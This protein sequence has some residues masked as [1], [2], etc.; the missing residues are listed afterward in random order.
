MIIYE[1]VKNEFMMDVE[2]DLLVTKVINNF[3]ER[4]GSTSE[5]EVNSWRNSLYRMYIV[6]NHDSIPPNV[7]IAIEYRIPTSSRRIDFIISGYGQDKGVAVIV[8]LKQWQ[9]VE[10]V[11]DK[12][13]I[14]RTVLGRG[15]RE[16]THPAYQVYSYAALLYDFNANVSHNSIRL[17]PCAYLHN[18]T[19]ELENDPLYD[20]SYQEYI[21]KAPVFDSTGIP[22]LRSFISRHVVKGD[23]KEILYLIE[24]GKIR[25]SKSLQDSLV[26]MLDGNAEFT[27]IDE[28]KVVYE[29]VKYSATQ[30]IASNRKK[31]IIVKG[32]PGTGKSVL[33][34][35]LLVHL[36]NQNLVCQYISKNSAPRQVYTAQLKGHKTRSS[37][38][39]LFKGSGVYYDLPCNDL[40]VALVD[41]AHRLNEKSGMFQ[42]KG[43]HQ[44][45]E[46][47]HAS[48]VSVFFID[49]QQRVHF[50]DVGKVKTIEGFAKF[51]NADTEIFE[52]TSQFRCNGSDGYIAFL[53]D[54]LAIRETANS[55]GFDLDYDLQIFDDPNQMFDQL[56][57]KNANNKA[58]L[59]AGYCWDWDKSGKNNPN[60]YDIVIDEYDFKMSWNLGNT[61]TYLIDPDSINQVGCIH[62]SQG[63]ELD[64]VG[65]I[66]GDDLS[67]RDG[68]IVT[69]FK[70]RSKNDQ[71]IKGLVGLMKTDPEKASTIADEII[72]NTYRVLL[73]R[74]QKGC[75][76][77]CTD[78]ALSEY[79]KERIAMASRMKR[80]FLSDR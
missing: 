75:Y 79:L 72:K 60:H 17:L 36:T 67:Y 49:E 62:T 3:R 48:R 43:E 41:E 16:T 2:K 28:Q 31:V 39:N 74:G 23:E 11:D 71:S 47:I 22:E 25:P 45:K 46:I 14:V 76:I 59:L 69:D 4:I 9:F 37:I 38:D 24:S 19:K 35:Q 57:Q 33:A 40:D 73:T 29:Q 27:M 55:D 66:I 63:L 13:G 53:D 61:G 18:Y 32:G 44:V 8:E 68:M 77:Y 64:Y 80:D 78:K 42:N 70:K 20:E 51:A 26:K 10:K 52:L 6:L 50:K 54:V 7:G 21:K 5:S 12:D 65:V 58:R 30:A 1:S 15:I 56:V 34:I